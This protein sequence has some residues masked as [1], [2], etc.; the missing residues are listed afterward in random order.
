MWCPPDGSQS[1]RLAVSGSEQSERRSRFASGTLFNFGGVSNLDFNS[2]RK[3]TFINFWYCDYIKT[4][5]CL[6]L[7]QKRYSEHSDY[8]SYSKHRRTENES[9]LDS[10]QG[11]P[12]YLIV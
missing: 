10:P 2:F 6:Y 9:S 8:T 1:R 5:L 3:N 11:K 12:T 4:F 7:G